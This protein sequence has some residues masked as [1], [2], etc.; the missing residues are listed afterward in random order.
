MGDIAIIGSGYVGLVTG[1]CLSEFGLHV[2]C[3]DKNVNKIAK[4]NACEVSIYEPGLKDLI[5]R[6]IDNKRLNFITDIKK[7]I[8]DNKVILIAVGTPPSSDGSADV[9]HVLE[10]AMEIGLKP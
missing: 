3:V 2:T 10:V 4:L 5:C 8:S 6:N 9:I 1:A 7:A